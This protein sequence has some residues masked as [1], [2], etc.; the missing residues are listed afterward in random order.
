MFLKESER[1]N[2]FHSSIATFVI[3]VNLSPSFYPIVI[4]GD[5][6]LKTLLQGRIE[7]T[8]VKYIE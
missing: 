8:E 6:S 3:K 4:R 2:D 1:A 7:L 5:Y